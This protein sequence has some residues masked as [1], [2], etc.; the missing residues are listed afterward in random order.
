MISKLMRWTEHGKQWATVLKQHGNTLWQQFLSTDGNT[1]CWM[2]WETIRLHNHYWNEKLLQLMGW[3]LAV[4]MVFNRPKQG[5]ERAASLWSALSTDPAGLFPQYDLI[6]VSECATVFAL[7]ENCSE[8]IYMQ[9]FPCTYMIWT[10]LN[11]SYWLIR[12]DKIL[13]APRSITRDRL[14]ESHVLYLSLAENVCLLCNALD[15][16]CAEPSV[17]VHCSY[18]DVAFQPYQ[19]KCKGIYKENWKLATT[20]GQGSVLKHLVRD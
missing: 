17:W 14:L 16:S 11:Q 15:R 12:V 6:C 10:T 13:D 2:A 18:A 9:V 7:A 1:N 4:K 20:L 3:C 8:R 19:Q 5:R